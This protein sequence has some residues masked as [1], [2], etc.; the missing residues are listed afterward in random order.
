MLQ[1]Q[2]SIAFLPS[3][4][5]QADL[6]ARS[7][8]RR[9]PPSYVINRFVDT[10]ATVAVVVAAAAVVI[11]GKRKEEGSGGGSSPPPPLFVSLLSCLAPRRAGRRRRVGKVFIGCKVGERRRR[12]VSSFARGRPGGRTFLSAPAGWRARQADEAPLNST[13]LFFGRPPPGLETKDLN[14]CPPISTSFLLS[15]FKFT[16][17]LPSSP[18]LYSNHFQ[19][20]YSSDEFFPEVVFVAAMLHWLARPPAG[21]AVK[22]PQHPFLPAAPQGS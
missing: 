5:R 22:V 15:F 18:S 1:R 8:G 17:R 13:Q 20:A 2:F 21:I 9:R 4:G 6:R 7:P 10:R 3:R 16:R 11:E 12:G 19:H 14:L